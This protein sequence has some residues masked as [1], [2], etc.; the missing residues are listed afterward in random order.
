MELFRRASWLVLPTLL[1]ITPVWAGG[2]RLGTFKGTRESTLSWNGR[3][4]ESVGP[5]ASTMTLRLRRDRN[6]LYITLPG[7]EGKGEKTFRHS[8]IVTSDKLLPNGDRVIRYERPANESRSG[9]HNLRAHE[10]ATPNSALRLIGASGRG[11]VIVSG[12]QARWINQGHGALQSKTSEEVIAR[13]Q[14]DE[15]T[16]GSR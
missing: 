16:T 12:N 11:V 7:E 10:E 15:T 3:G 9:R 14:W 2:P 6:R 13:V 8:M 4:A 5:V 1:A